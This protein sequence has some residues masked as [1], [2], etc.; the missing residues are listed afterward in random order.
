MS[1]GYV[2]FQLLPTTQNYSDR[3]GWQ[4][5]N[6]ITGNKK[7]ESISQVEAL[8]QFLCCRKYDCSSTDDSVVRLSMKYDCEQ[9]I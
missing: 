4:A 3:D 1:C 2:P 6:V 7:I 8:F 9:G 5:L